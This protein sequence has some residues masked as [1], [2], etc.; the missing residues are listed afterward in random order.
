[1]TLDSVFRQWAQAI[2]TDPETGIRSIADGVKA[3]KVGSAR[4]YA[5]CMLVDSGTDAEKNDLSAVYPFSVK[6][7]SADGTPFTVNMSKD[8][9]TVNA[10]ETEA[11][12]AGGV[13]PANST[14]VRYFVSNDWELGSATAFAAQQT[15]GNLYW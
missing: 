15:A 2:Q 9:R 14:L 4:G 7:V 11:S 8:D 13:V 10:S 3:A 6:F 1:M 12:A 5:E